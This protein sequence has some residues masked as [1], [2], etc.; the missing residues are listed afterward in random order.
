MTAAG[1]IIL[2]GTDMTFEETVGSV[3]SEAGFDVIGRKL[4]GIYEIVGIFNSIEDWGGLGDEEK[5]PGFGKH[6]ECILI[7]AYIHG[8]SV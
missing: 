1:F 7:L 6:G 8:Q 3:F 4:L 2:D 5:K